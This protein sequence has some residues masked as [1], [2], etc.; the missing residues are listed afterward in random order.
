MVAAVPHGPGM[1]LF[2]ALTNQGWSRVPAT[3]GAAA[4][5]LRKIL[6]IMGFPGAKVQCIG[7]HSCKATTLS[8]MSKFGETLEIRSQ[9]GYHTTRN[10]ALIYSR[11]AMA[12]PIRRLQFVL[13]QIRLSR[14]MPDMT[15]SGYFPGAA[16]EETENITDDNTTDSPESSDS[17]DSADEED[18]V[19]DKTLIEQAADAEL[20]AWSEHATI[21]SLALDTPPSLFRN[22]S[23]RY[24][25]IVAD[26]SGA[27]FRCGREV[28]TSYQQLSEVPRFCTPQC[29][30]CF[31]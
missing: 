18:D 9:L 7:T 11:D 15:R 22:A 5:W 23:T 10:S 21:E 19:K 25:H 6:L 4:D 13:E 14:F 20:D 31:R 27:R 26:E 3:A 17:E 28:T 8:W 12:G 2:P 1:P 24:I 29:R 30:Q 16:S